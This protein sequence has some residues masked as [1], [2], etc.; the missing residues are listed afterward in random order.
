MATELTEIKQYIE[1]QMLTWSQEFFRARIA[2]LRQAK[3]HASGALESSFE[4]DI[5]AQVRRESVELL[6][7]F[8]DHGRFIDMKRLK[9]GEGNRAYVDEII[10]WIQERG[11]DSRFI[12]NY[13]KKHGLKKI[14]ERVLAGVA[15]GIIR[16]RNAGQVRRRRWY[17]PSKTAA[18][19]QLFTQVAA[20]LPD[21]VG[22]AIAKT[23]KP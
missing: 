9:G 16:K 12:R 22:P 15:W 19:T 4:S 1:R 2:F 20:G 7:A 13:L 3:I 18:I 6:L 5:N 8:E 10:A 21:V 23:F 17:N 11:L 14:P